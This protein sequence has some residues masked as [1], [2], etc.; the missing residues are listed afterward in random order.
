VHLKPL[1]Y[2]PILK[3]GIPAVGVISIDGKDLP[4]SLSDIPQI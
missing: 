2:N 3:L 1:Q 4:S